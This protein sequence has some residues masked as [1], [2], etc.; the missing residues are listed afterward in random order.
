M[1]LSREGLTQREISVR[2]GVPLGTVR[3]WQRGRNRSAPPKPRRRRR[4]PVPDLLTLPTPDYPYLLGFYLGDGCLSRQSNGSWCLRIVSDASYPA[5][6]RE[7]QAAMES[8][9]GG[10]AWQ[11]KRAGQHAFELG[12]TWWHW[13]LVFPQ[14]G[15]GR[16]HSRRIVL[17][18]WQ[19]NLIEQDPRPFLRGLIHSDGWRGLNR[20]R[21]KGKDYAYPR[22]Q[23]S[24]RS[25]D[26][27]ALFTWACDLMAIEWRPWGRTTSRSRV[28]GPWPSWTNSSVPSAD[29]RA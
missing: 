26:I 6:L 2:T 23:F 19:R 1:S 14:H 15:P 24:N 9:S 28:G 5:L 3:N 17:A 8:V 22:Y 21:V 27:K 12:L 7:A 13:P 29:R 10:T 11:R 25:Q 20:V 18:D 16:K 4:P